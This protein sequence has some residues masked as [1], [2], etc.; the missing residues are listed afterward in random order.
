MINSNFHGIEFDRRPPNVSILEVLDQ[1]LVNLL[2]KV[3]NGAAFLLQ[4]DRILEIGQLSFRL[5][6]ESDQTQ[7][8]PNFLQ[9]IVKVP[10]VMS[11]NGNA[12]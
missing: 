2:A 10:L 11:G 4:N 8:V 6:V 9:Q 5:G 7:V 12:V 1:R 3:L